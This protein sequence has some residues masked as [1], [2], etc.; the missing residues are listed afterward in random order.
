MKRGRQLLR[1]AL[2]VFMSLAIV[3]TSVNMPTM[4]VM[5][6]P[7]TS[8]EVTVEPT[9]I[10]ETVVEIET[11]SEETADGESEES[12]EAISDPSE[13]TVIEES[14][15]E[16]STS[17]ELDEEETTETVVET[18]EEV[19]TEEVTETV[20]SELLNTILSNTTS[21]TTDTNVVISEQTSQAFVGNDVVLTYTADK[22]DFAFAT[23]TVKVDGKSVDTDKV[24]VDAED[25]EITLAASLFDNAGVYDI[26][27]VQ[28]GC[29]FTPVYQRV[30]AT[31]TTDQWGSPIWSDEFNGN[32]LDSSKWDHQIGLGTEYTDT[33][34]G[35]SEEQYYTD[36]TENSYVEGG[37]LTI[38][39]IKDEE[40]GYTSA[41]IRSTN[42][43]TGK[44]GS[45]YNDSW[46]LYNN[47]YGKI[48]A[49]IKLPAGKG[50]W[51]AFWMLPENSMYGTWAASGEIDIMEAKGRLPGEVVG[52][53][54]YGGAWPNNTSTGKTYYFDDSTFEEY[55]IYGIEWDPDEIRWYVDGELYSTLN[56]W[57]AEAGEE[58]NFPYPAPFDEEFHLLFNMAVGGTFDSEVSSAEVEVDENGVCMD[59]DYVRWYQR[60]G[61]YDNWEIEQP[62]TEKDT[63][64][65]ATEL[66]ALA[67]EVG[68]YIKDTDFSEMDTTPK[69]TDGS[70]TIARGNWIALLIPGNGNGDAAWSKTT[71]DEKNYLKVQVKNVGSKVY[72]SQMIQY[73][74]AVKGY[75]YEI[76]YKAYTDSAD[77][78]SD[79]NLKIGGDGDNDW[80]TYSGNYTDA[81]ST[82]PTTYKHSFTMSGAT[83]PTARFE[84][85][86]ATSAGTVYITDVAVKILENGI[87]EDEGQDDAKEP[88]SDGNHIYNGEFNIGS[89]G[90]LYWHWGTNDEANIV[91]ST[92]DGSDFIAN[93]TEATSMWQNGMNLLQNDTYKVT[94]DVN[95]TEAQTLTVSL[96][97]ADGTVYA[98]KEVSLNAGANELETE[99]TMPADSTDTTGVFKITFNGAATID[100]VKMIRTSNNNLDWDS[101][102]FWPL[103]NG[104][105][106]NGTDGWNIWSQGGGGQSNTVGE[107]G[108]LAWTINMPTDGNYWDIGAESR[109]MT[110]TKGIKYKVKFDYEIP[111]DAGE[112]IISYKFTDMTDPIEATLSGSGTYESD[113]LLASGN[114]ALALYFGSH[115][116]SEVTIKLDNI[117]VYV[118]PD[119][120]IV[121]S[122]YAKPVSL[123]QKGYGYVNAIA[124]AEY[125]E[126]ENWEAAAKTFYLNGTEIPAADVAINT[127][128]NTLAITGTHFTSEGTYTFAVKAD[129]FLKTQE[130]KLNVLASSN[131]LLNGD[132]SNE[133]TN[134]ETW[135]VNGCGDYAVNDDGILEITHKWNEGEPWHIQLFQ[136]GLEYEAGSYVIEFDAS[137]SVERP[138]TVQL[139]NGSGMIAGSSN[140]PVLSTDQ[141]H[142]KFVLKDLAKNSAIK[143][144]VMA[145]N[146][147]S[148]GVTTPNE[149]DNQNHK[150]YLD[151][152]EFRPA[153]EDDLSGNILKNGTFYNGT[154]NWNFYFADWTANG[155]FTV[156][157]EGIGV[158]K[159]F[160]N[161][162]ADWHLQLFQ[163]GIAYEAGTYVV[164]FDA[165]ADVERPIG[166]QLQNGDNV[167]SGTAQKA[168]LSTESQ[169]Y[170]YILNDLAANSD[171]KFDFPM[172]N[173]TMD[174]AS[175]PNTEH[176]IYVDNIMFRPAVEEDFATT[177]G[178]IASAG[179][180]AV[181]EA[182]TINYAKAYKP[183]DTTT[184]TVYVNDQKIA[185]K[186]VKEVKDAEGNITGLTV[187]KRFFKKAD[188]YSI[189]VA[190][191]GF[192]N[193]NTIRQYVY[194]VDG[195]RLFDSA[196]DGTGYW[197]VYDEDE[198]N[199][200]NGEIAGGRYTLDYKAG[201][202]HPDWEGNPWVTWSSQLK[203][204]N[205]FLE[206]GKEYKLRFKAN[207]DMTGGRVIGVEFKRAGWESG[208]SQDV[209]IANATD[210]YEI[211]LAPTETAEDYVVLFK[212]GPIGENLQ[213]E[214]PG[215]GVA[216]TLML[217]SIQL[218]EAN[219]APEMPGEKPEDGGLWIKNI[220]DQT[221]TGKAI[222]PV[223]EVYEGDTL[224]GKK[225]Y[226]VSYKNNKNAGTATVTVKGKGNYTGSDTTTFEILRKDIAEEDVTAADLSAVI[227]SKNGTV[228][229]PKVTV[230]YGKI[231][232]KA[233][234]AKKAN[235]YSLTYDKVNGEDGKAIA[236]SY[237]VVITGNGNYTGTKT[238]KYDVL[239][240]DILLM[241]K[242]KI[243]FANGSIK[244]I[245]YA[246]QNA[247]P[248]FVVKIDNTTLTEGT[249][250]EIEY[251]ELKV[252]KN[253]I[254][255]KAKG[256]NVYGSKTYS[257]NVT[258]AKITAS[259][260]KIETPEVLKF[261]YTGSPVEFGANGIAPITVTKT[262]VS[263]G[264]EEPVVDTLEE[265]TD[266]E[267][268]YSKQHT[269]A[270]KA[271]VTV[272]G[273]G[274]YTGKKVI[275]YT[276]EKVDMSKADSNITVELGSESVVYNKKGATASVV[277]KHNGNVVDPKF[278]K[279]TYKNYKAVST[280]DKPAS[281][282]ITG[283]TNFK[284]STAPLT[285]KV[286]KSD[287]SQITFTAADAQ[288]PSSMNPAK[289]KAALTIKETA[290]NKALKSKTDYLK[291]IEYKIEDENAEGGYRDITVEDLTSDTI[292]TAIITLTGNYGDGTTTKMYAPFRLYKTKAS[293]FKVARLDSV[294]YEG[295]VEHKVSLD[296]K[297]TIRVK[298]NGKTVTKTLVEGT[299]YT[300]SYSKNTAVGTAKVTI[301]GIHE[302]GG[303][304]SATFK[305]TK[306]KMDFVGVMSFL[307]DLF[308]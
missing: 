158:I 264:A 122:G 135:S 221:Y 141:K 200:S 258:G 250:Y 44:K 136:N 51:P 130:A 276:I 114:A 189:Y 15:E 106:F 198:T 210:V 197:E 285:Y 111:V 167:I 132:F 91:K 239:K 12:T 72:S 188:I 87:S 138:I 176:T 268:V 58:G 59:I 13:E 86:L 42:A 307:E 302:Y 293:S 308:N 142:Y 222:K 70:W 269:N 120:Y 288:I 240:S 212:L 172:G 30:Y 134:W 107:D 300:V 243:S 62:E 16:I 280:E 219:V 301:T 40:L 180:T 296:N 37:K 3:F 93:V 17:E 63:S 28:E 128:A 182:V 271:S 181:N 169:H 109:S 60:E 228:K 287:A 89:D 156:N 123:R 170:K 185:S 175:T 1:R 237:N 201:Y 259:N 100:S 127:T 85:N 193:T 157:D 76:S 206:A 29:T 232:L 92:I 191:T 102:S 118:D 79:I 223:I 71:I 265:G 214:T 255:F 139:E 279:V 20:E 80:S 257:V 125:S 164:E 57:Y 303:T 105:F 4:T 39:A 24:S 160:G 245:D 274:G 82:T 224:L 284:N 225:D 194:T 33:G 230:K 121:P 67:D 88:L 236:G 144:L 50:I 47:A 263:E 6:A 22:N 26:T 129:G 187:D 282:I 162:G 241:S 261:P 305:I 101:I 97:K 31:D 112:K 46:A 119:S 166:V 304:K 48:E 61:G 254:T 56:N 14:S 34:W 217:D 146:V 36:S 184:K 290:T 294:V 273:K 116:T 242:A 150:I 238:I 195:N 267:L 98:S 143:F 54:H 124:T 83:D 283:K 117:E 18:T 192:E 159:H 77:T 252:G 84:F 113:A 248:S 277:V 23:Y 272:V 173:V 140:S 211:T 209:P 43:E 186:Y 90:L 74:P 149:G 306:K 55:H 53:I 19:T 260:I 9:T 213:T 68:N 202:R 292:V 5:A 41:R 96:T 177:P 286:V 262:T 270:G 244:A 253:T 289:V 235:D 155:N 266:Y 204:E 178:V 256:E 291:T 38:K 234:T 226:T 2:T 297:V 94:A 35:N 208:P 247:K 49:K 7:E 8:E 278:Y 220:A 25:K 133:L 165:W 299:D 203:Q 215:E 145:G 199:L 298:E 126:N 205:I 171:V 148:G 207:T 183:W 64:E 103:Y 168:L 73:F 66:L 147:T 281:V 190:A 137:A 218:F 275:K 52:T 81:L 216:H 174:S 295:P 69:T 152:I 251:P 45:T 249:D 131:L 11:S 78:K 108:K 163:E 104:D 95:S 179:V 99:L 231:T 233:A 227:N 27:F 65:T 161:G 246:N 32:E 154:K 229:N 21:N 196:L 10:E 110:L 75:S 151:N 153:T 115:A